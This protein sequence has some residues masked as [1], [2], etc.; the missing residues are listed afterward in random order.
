MTLLDREFIA[1]FFKIFFTLLALIA[2]VFFA[3]VLLDYF[4]DAAEGAGIHWALLLYLCRLPAFL[5]D[6]AVV[7]ASASIL[8]NVARR[9]RTNEILAYLAGGISPLRLALPFLGAALI[10]AGAALSLSEYVVADAERTGE[11]I[12][13][14]WI[15]NKP[16]E[17][18]TRS[19]DIF[20][21]WGADR[22]YVIDSY[23]PAANTMVEPTIVDM[24]PGRG[25]PRSFLHARKAE[26]DEDGAGW[27]FYNA[28]IRELDETGRITG[29][30]QYEELRD[31]E[32]EEP[33][34]SRVAEFLGQLDDP[35]KMNIRQL[36]RY[37]M[38]LDA[39]GKQFSEY[40]LMM[41]VRLAMPLAVVV[42]SLL[43]C[44][45]VLRPRDHGVFFDFGGGLLLIAL[46]YAAFLLVSR[47][48]KADIGVPPALVAWLP[49][50]IFAVLGIGLFFKTNR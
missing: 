26:L 12:E 35:E 39:Q 4:Q 50:G 16:I 14:R 29:F 8:W 21:N 25:A 7:L 32:L 1:D 5:V 28:T 30:R 19:E 9:S 13:E 45:H 15:K 31:S 2:V 24:W 47:L 46:Y 11:F 41:H 23:D 49:N 36:R 40:E 22:F 48:G 37:M 33:L 17:R 34:S 6:S 3:S 42:V 38:L 27:T 44:A 18:V 10:V 43:M 20:Q